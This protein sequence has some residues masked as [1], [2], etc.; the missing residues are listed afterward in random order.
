MKDLGR[1]S[2][3]EHVRIGELAVRLGIDVLVGCGAEMAH[4]TSAAAR[5]S[6]GRLAPHPTRVAHVMSTGDALSIVQGLC[7]AGD[8]VL[9]K[10]SRAMEME[11]VAAA[12]VE[13]FGGAA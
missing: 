9:V 12:L 10:G 3:S 4:A 11:H 1:F 2:N 6:G 8:V 13:Q 5:L 7:R